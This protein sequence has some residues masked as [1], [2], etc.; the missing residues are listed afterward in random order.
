MD[1]TSLAALFT[2]AE[3]TTFFAG[4]FAEKS[5]DGL[6]AYARKKFSKK[7]I[8]YQLMDA[9]EDTFRETVGFFGLDC[10]SEKIPENFAASYKNLGTIGTEQELKHLLSKVFSGDEE[11][12]EIDDDVFEFWFIS[13]HR[14]LIDSKRQELKDFIMVHQLFLLQDQVAQLNKTVGILQRELVR[15]TIKELNAPSNPPCEENEPSEDNDSKNESDPLL[16]EIG[17]ELMNY[18]IRPLR[19]SDAMEVD[20]VDNDHGE[21][22]GMYFSLTNPPHVITRIFIVKKKIVPSKHSITLHPEPLEFTV[23]HDEYNNDIYTFFV[24]EQST[25]DNNSILFFN[26]DNLNKCAYLYAG[27]IGDGEI[28][29]VKEGSTIVLERDLRIA[30]LDVGSDFFCSAHEE[31]AEEYVLDK[32]R[33][34]FFINPRNGEIVRQIVRYDAEE[35]V[36]KCNVSMEPH[37]SYVSFYIENEDND[38]EKVSDYDIGYAYAHENEY[39]LELNAYKAMHWFMV[40][41]QDGDARAYYEMGRIYHYGIGFAR[42][43]EKAEGYYRQALKHGI[44]KARKALKEIQAMVTQ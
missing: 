13:F 22:D 30:D 20:D 34:L 8:E 42:D 2:V 24:S 11:G 43:L 12:V 9:L 41:A 36:Y 19:Q 44:K 37:R 38:D 7:S 3:V 33:L 26:F 5:L 23:E 15:E 28:I 17:I 14:Q 32:N 4:Y 35:Q 39:D 31:Q 18:Q 25:K 16:Q 6:F 40:A 27:V 1:I 21:E 10:D 29:I